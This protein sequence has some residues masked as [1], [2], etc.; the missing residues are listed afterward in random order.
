MPDT[1]FQERLS[2]IAAKTQVDPRQAQAPVKQG[3]RYGLLSVGC[4]MLAFGLQVIKFA[5]EGYD[6][7][8]ET[9]VALAIGLA[10]LGL[11]MLVASG[12]LIVKAVSGANG[13]PREIEEHRPASVARRLSWIAFGLAL[14]LVAGFCMG[15]ASHAKFLARS[16]GPEVE[17]ISGGGF[18]LLAFLLAFIALSSGLTGFSR[19]RRVLLPVPVFF[20]IGVFAMMA[21]LQNGIIRPG[22]LYASGGLIE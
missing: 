20:L 14:G 10:I 9:S 6:Q 17:G 13:R 18:V 15:L 21:M 4:L 7:I 12:V 16:T 5:N 19:R 1:D 3:V 22:E 11:G 2:R 8:K